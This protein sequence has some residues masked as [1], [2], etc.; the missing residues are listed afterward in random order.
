MIEFIGED[1]WRSFSV[2]IK[3]LF[4]KPDRTSAGRQKLDHEKVF[5]ETVKQFEQAEIEHLNDLTY[6]PII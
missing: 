4:R 3:E 5:Q 2:F 6:D 1:W